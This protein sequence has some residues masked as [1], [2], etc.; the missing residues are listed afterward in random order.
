MKFHF[1]K[2]EK[3]QPIIYVLISFDFPR[4]VKKT[5]EG[6][7]ICRAENEGGYTEETVYLLT[8]SKKTF[9][10][11]VFLRRLNTDNMD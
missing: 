3:H 9:S 2:V 1:L 7:Y 4:K 11:E 5:D 6:A 8:Q 10:I